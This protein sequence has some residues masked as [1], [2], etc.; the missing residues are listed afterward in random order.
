MG[1]DNDVMSYMAFLVPFN[2]FDRSDQAY[3]LG[4]NPHLLVKFPSKHR[5]DPKSG[6]ALLGSIR[7]FV[8]E[9]EHRWRGKP[10][11]LFRTMLSAASAS[12]SPTSTMPPGSE[13][14][15]SLGGLPRA[16][17]RIRPS[18]RTATEAARTGREG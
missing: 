4:L 6:F 13:N 1:G 8:L 14:S 9:R 11:P 12:V 16:A 18:R 3:K 10:D 17:S 15:P 7:C 2:E 5:M